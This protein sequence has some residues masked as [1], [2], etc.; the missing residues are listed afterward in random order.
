MRTLH[1]VFCGGF[2]AST[3]LYIF[4]PGNVVRLLTGLF[5][6]PTFASK[7]GR[8]AMPRQAKPTSV[9]L[10]RYIPKSI[11]HALKVDAAAHGTSLNRHIISILK[12]A[13]DRTRIDLKQRMKQEENYANDL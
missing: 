10:I 11:H 9:I 5:D 6:L 8:R 2:I 3:A 12:K 7:G 13:S 1:I 4:F